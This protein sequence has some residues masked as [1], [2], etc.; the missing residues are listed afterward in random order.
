M[1]SP[2]RTARKAAGNSEREIMSNFNL[3]KIAV[4]VI[5]SII[6]SVKDIRKDI[7]KK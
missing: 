4:D 3:V 7:M 2:P 6:D 5:I 1:M